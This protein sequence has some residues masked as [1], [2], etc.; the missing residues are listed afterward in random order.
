MPGK[1]ANSV[2]HKDG[3]ADI[4]DLSRLSPS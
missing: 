2:E 4:H 3:V 1:T